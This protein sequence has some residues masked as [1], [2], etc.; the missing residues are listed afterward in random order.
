MQEDAGYN[1]KKNYAL[2]KELGIFD[3]YIDFKSHNVI[4][5]AKSELWR[6]KLRLYREQK[7]IWQ[8]TYRFRVI[9]EGV[10]SAIKRKNLNYLRSKKEVAQD[11]EILLKCLVYNLTVIG[12][13][14]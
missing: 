4:R 11:V 1:S 5:R 2:C 7:E 6:E 8:E 14:S 13:Y 3:T 10:F 9:I 12:K